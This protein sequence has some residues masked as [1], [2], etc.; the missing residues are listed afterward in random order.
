MAISGAGGA[1]FESLLAGL[2]KSGAAR[3]VSFDRDV[4]PVARRVTAEQDR[5][6]RFAEELERV[7]GEVRRVG[8]GDLAQMIV[9]ILADAGVTSAYV[10]A[11]TL[12]ECGVDVGAL[13]NALNQQ[14]IEAASVH[15]DETLFAVSAS[16]SGVEWGVAELGALVCCSGT[17]KPRSASLIPEIHVAIVPTDRVIADLCDAFG[18]LA[19]RG[20]LPANVN[21]IAGPSKTA[22]I[23]GVLVEGVHGPR[24]VVAIVVS[25]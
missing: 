5:V 7:G 18:A 22:D 25:R 12:A 21:L 8:S 11:A 2:E 16:V 14:E 15:D 19:S 17:G 23:E 6:G 13:T 9:A 4:E 24:R 20:E 10:D 3:A 1:E